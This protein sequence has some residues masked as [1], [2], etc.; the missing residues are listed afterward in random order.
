MDKKHL[1][2]TLIEMVT[3]IVVMGV[4]MAGVLMGVNQVLVT[5]A[6]P[7]GMTQ[8]TFLANARKEIIL[9][10]REVS[11][12]TTL[13]D[14]CPGAAALCSPLSTFASTNGF[15]PVTPVITGTSIKTI[16]VQVSGK[17]NATVI[18]QVANYD[19]E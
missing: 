11:G 2:F 16:T 12:V 3:F 6:V 7:D 17:A 10:S 5:A 15:D 13:S 19:Q 1:G 9:L 4:L 18:S 8:A 14:P